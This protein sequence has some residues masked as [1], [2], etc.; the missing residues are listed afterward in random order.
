[1]ISPSRLPLGQFQY[2]IRVLQQIPSAAAEIN[3]SAEY[4]S[5]AG[6][7]RF[8]Q[9]ASGVLVSAE[10]TG[11]PMSEAACKKH[12]FAFH[13]HSGGSC[14][15]TAN[16]AFANALAHYNPDNCEHPNHAGDLLSLW[17]NKGSVFEIFLTDRFSVNEILGKSVIV[18]LNPDDFTTQPSGNAGQKIACGKIEKRR[19]YRL[20]HGF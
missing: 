6:E 10:I 3:G 19:P 18:H 20:S 9:T 2:F 11:L 4:P 17:S 1:M 8:Y 15:G 16:D 13:I 14:T 7:V 5:I 12:I